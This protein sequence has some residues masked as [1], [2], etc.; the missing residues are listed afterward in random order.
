MQECIEER[1]IF[2][3]RTMHLPISGN[4]RPTRHD[5]TPREKRLSETRLA[6]LGPR[7]GGAA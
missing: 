1:R 7:K 4:Q 2:S 5:I 6:W 3:A